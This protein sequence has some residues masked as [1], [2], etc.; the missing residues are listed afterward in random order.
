MSQSS[1]K[2]QKAELFGYL[3]NDKTK[4]SGFVNVESKGNENLKKLVQ[5]FSS[6]EV[7][8]FSGL[9]HQSVVGIVKTLQVGLTH[10]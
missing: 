3:N 10:V 6:K 2:Q 1:F 7:E 5:S 9:I 4:L 8:V